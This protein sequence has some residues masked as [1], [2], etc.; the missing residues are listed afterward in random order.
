MAPPSSGPSTLE[1]A[2]TDE[3]MAMYVGY[4]AGGTIRGVMTV[5]SE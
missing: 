3:M 2:N 1:I 5:T 4:L